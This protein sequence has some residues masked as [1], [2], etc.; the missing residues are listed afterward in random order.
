MKS[1]YQGYS[2]EIEG[3]SYYLQP[4]HYHYYREIL[5]RLHKEIMAMLS[6]HSKLLAFRIDLHLHDYSAD[7]L[8]MSKMIKKLKKKLRVKYKVQNIGH[9]WAREQNEAH[10]QHYHLALWLDGNKVRHPANI[11]K[12]IEQIWQGWDQPQPYT[13]KDCYY[14]IERQNKVILKSFYKRASYLAKAKDKG[15]RAKT[16]NDFSCSRVKPKATLTSLM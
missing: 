13:P 7:S 1:I 9:I 4:N 15:K 5:E 8:L 10:Q 6:H 16:A 14:L 12:I 11:I 3:E 2:I